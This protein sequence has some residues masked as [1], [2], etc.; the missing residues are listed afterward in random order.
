MG[1][2]IADLVL[3]LYGRRLPAKSE[4][5]GDKQFLRDFI[6][7]ARFWRHTKG[8]GLLRGPSSAVAVGFEPTEAC[9]SHA[10]EVCERPFGQT[11]HDASAQVKAHM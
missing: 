9:T 3:M 6:E 2:P 4:V 7:A 1:A 10:F 5:T 8:P 11:R